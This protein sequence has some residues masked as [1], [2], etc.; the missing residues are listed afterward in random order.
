MEL[1]GLEQPWLEEKRSGT[2]GKSELRHLW[3]QMAL[4]GCRFG[5]KS[6]SPGQVLPLIEPW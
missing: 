2:D 6:C 1:N 3:N 5:Q 4:E